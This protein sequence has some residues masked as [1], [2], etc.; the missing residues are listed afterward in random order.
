MLELGSMPVVTTMVKVGGHEADGQA[1]EAG[2]EKMEA[3]GS[4]FL[5]GGSEGRMLAVEG[6]GL[7]D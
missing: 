1:G 2:E 3:H 4:L 6:R 7:K 5:L